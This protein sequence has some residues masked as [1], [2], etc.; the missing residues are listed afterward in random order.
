[1]KNCIDLVFSDD[2]TF[3]SEYTLQCALYNNAKKAGDYKK[4]ENKKE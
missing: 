1:M 4:W 3:T 2:I